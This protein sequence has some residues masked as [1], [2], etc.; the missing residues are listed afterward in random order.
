MDWW[1]WKGSIHPSLDSLSA[2]QSIPDLH[3]KEKSDWPHGSLVIPT[4]SSAPAGD[5]SDSVF[6]T[7]FP[8]LWENP[9]IFKI[10]ELQGKPIPLIISHGNLLCQEDTPGFHGTATLILCGAD[11]QNSQDPGTIQDGIHL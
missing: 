7:R 11:Q 10:Q 6:P 9:I 8:Q 5:P 4:L 1:P 3:G 2:F